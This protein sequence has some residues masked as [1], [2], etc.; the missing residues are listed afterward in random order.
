MN[1]TKKFVYD[2]NHDGQR[3]VNPYGVIIEIPKN[4]KS[5]YIRQNL[6]S[7]FKKRY[8]KN[9]DKAVDFASNIENIDQRCTITIEFCGYENSRYVVRFCGSYIDNFESRCAANIA[10]F[11]HKKSFMDD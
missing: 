7:P 1:N 9:F 6:Y 8:F 10:A 5:F 4:K 3:W 2:H 11:E